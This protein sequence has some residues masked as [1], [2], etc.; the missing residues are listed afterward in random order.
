VGG[1]ACNSVNVA[2]SLLFLLSKEHG[3]KLYERFIEALNIQL[4]IS[5][6][7]LTTTHNGKTKHIFIY[8]YY[9]QRIESVVCRHHPDRLFIKRRV[10][11]HIIHRNTT[12]LTYTTTIPIPPPSRISSHSHHG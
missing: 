11:P 10:L 1:L 6:A 2:F 9:Q 7:Q 4:D 8:Y 12:L 3:N 5:L